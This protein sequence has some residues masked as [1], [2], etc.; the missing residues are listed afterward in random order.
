MSREGFREGSREGVAFDLS[1]RLFGIFLIFMNQ[2]HVIFPV[3]Q[4]TIYIYI[5]TQNHPL[6]SF[7]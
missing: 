7:Y 1:N 5:L 6:N 4:I 2:H 3:N